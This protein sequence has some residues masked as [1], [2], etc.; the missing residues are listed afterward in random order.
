MSKTGKIL[1]VDDYE[2]N[3]HGLAQ[4]L[5]GANYHVLMAANGSE[6]LSLVAAERPDLVLLDVMMPGISGLEVCER[7]KQDADTCLIPVVLISASQERQ[8]MLAGL[9]AGADDFL[10]KPVDPKELYT[11]VR[12]LM[13]LKRLTDDLE[14]AASLFLT[15]GRV[16]EARDP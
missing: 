14:S 2:P 11:R 9:E 13:R 3:L 15:L 16:I 12:S 10:S 6:A 7:V 8:T 5:E 4:L 1:V